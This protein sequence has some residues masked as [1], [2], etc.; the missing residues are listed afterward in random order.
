MLLKLLTA[1]ERIVVA[2]FGGIESKYRIAVLN[3]ITA[4]RRAPGTA[5]QLAQLIAQG[6]VEQAL[7][8]AV[9]AGTLRLSQHYSA[10]YVETGT[11]TAV[12]MTDILDAVVD[13]N[14]VHDRAVAHM[15]GERLRLIR[16]FGSEQ[17]RATRLALSD[18]ITRGANPVE[19]AR[20]FRG[21]IGLT[22]KQ[23]QSVLNYRSYLE[24]AADG[25]TTALNRNLRDRRFDRTIR[26]SVRTGQPLSTQ[27]IDGM[28]TRYR[29]R[30]VKYRSQVIAR[31]EA[32]RSVHSAQEE[33]TEQAIEDGSIGRGD[34]ERTW[35]AAAD[36]RVRD[37]H[38]TLNGVVRG[39]DEPF[40]GLA[41]PILYPGDPAAP[42]EET[43]QC[44]CTLAITI[45]PS[46]AL[47]QA[48]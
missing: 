13:F 43:V 6:Q 35:I 8:V 26:S 41:G 22:Q 45:K 2:N 24:R 5:A 10:V 9:R 44:R 37:S 33:A 46:T 36:D 19:Q 3:A 42:P 17:R 39:K 18:G 32:L 7:D 20:A 21:S 15:Q 23:E 28:T 29:E 47:Q 12:Q 11:S 27:Q 40:P 4:A 34:I 1:P 31:T 14:Q 30:Y 16:E 38:V 48:A 25:D